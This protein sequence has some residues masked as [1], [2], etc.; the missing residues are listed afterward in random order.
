[1]NFHHFVYLEN[2]EL[3]G[4][5]NNDEDQLMLSFSADKNGINLIEDPVLIMQ[6]FEI[7]QIACGDGFTLMLKNN[8]ELWLFGLEQRSVKVMVDVNIKDIFCEKEHSIILKNNGDIFNFSHNFNKMD[9]LV[10]CPDVKQ[11]ACGLNYTVI[12]KKD[13]TILIFGKNRYNFNSIKN[14]DKII[15][16]RNHIFVLD[17]SNN[18]YISGDNAYNQFG[19]MSNISEY[20][21]RLFDNFGTRSICSGADHTMI[22]KNNGELCGFGYNAQEQLGLD[23]SDSV[24]GV[25]SIMNDVDKV[26]C[27][28]NSTVILKNNELWFAGDIYGC[29]KYGRRR[30]HLLKKFDDVKIIGINGI[31]FGNIEWK[32]E[33]NDKLSKET[34]D[35]IF[36]FLM[37][38]RYFDVKYKVKMVKYM[39]YEVIKYLFY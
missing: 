24:N 18:L 36:M 32:P 6:D 23:H 19:D 2:G 5:G 26:I 28:F 21:L 29:G 38:C 16:G 22:L 39:K 37:V 13:D 8:G 14:I 34:K 27:G 4:F 10:N 17:N 20:S 11:I 31:R 9:L 7:R 12:L 1:M 33:Y 35:I 25:I 15:C 30:L 3:W